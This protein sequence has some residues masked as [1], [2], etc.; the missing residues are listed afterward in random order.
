MYFFKFCI[1]IIAL[2]NTFTSFLANNITMKKQQLES[3]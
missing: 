1:T 3:K 2:E